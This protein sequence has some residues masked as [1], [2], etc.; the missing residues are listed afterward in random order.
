MLR[1]VEKIIVGN[2][3]FENLG[4]QGLEQLVQESIVSGDYRALQK[5]TN[6]Y[7][8]VYDY[9]HRKPWW[10]LSDFDADVWLVDFTDDKKKTQKKSNTITKMLDWS[11]VYL[12]DAEPLT[13]IKHRKLLNSFKYWITAVDNPLENGGNLI[14]AKTA[15]K[16]FNIV[17]HLINAILLHS[18]SLRLAQLQLHNVNDDF[19]LNILIQIAIHG[20]VSGIYEPDFRIKQLLDKESLSITDEQAVQFEKNYPYLSKSLASDD[21]KLSLSN[22]AKACAWLFEQGFYRDSLG[23]LQLQGN[24]AVLNSLMFDGEVLS[25]DSA[26]PAYLELSLKAPLL[27]TEYPAAA[28]QNTSAETTRNVISAYIAAIR[29]ICTNL[30]RQDAASPQ[31]VGQHVTAVSVSQN[32]LVK[33][34]KPARTRTLPPEFVFNLIRQCY[35]FAKEHLPTGGLINTA[36]PSLLS[37][38]LHCMTEGIS[39]SVQSRPSR[40]AKAFNKALHGHVPTTERGHWFQNEAINCLSP[41]Y[42]SKGITQINTFAISVPNRHKR[43]RANESLFDLFDVLQGSIQIIIGAIMAR[44]QDELV[45]LK[46]HGNLSPNIN[47]FTEKG[48]A[49]NYSLK[50]EVKKTGVGGKKGMNERI[51]RPIPLSIAKFIWQLEQ[52]NIE[53]TQRHLNKG[54]LSLFNCLASKACRLSSLNYHSFNKHLD[55]VCDYFETDLVQY[56]TGEYRRNYVRQHQLRRFF[57]MAFFWSKRFRGMEALRWMLAHSDIEHLYHYISESE[58]GTVLTGVKATTITRSITDPS[59]EL[60]N[61]EEIEELRKVIA[62]RVLGDESKAVELSTLSDA[63]EY[64]EDESYR[65]VP[66]ISQ[67]QKEQAIENEIIDMLEVGSITL[68][69]EFFTI[70][71]VNGDEVRTF[72]LMLRIKDLD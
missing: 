35:E 19:W 48:A 3:N 66:L 53:V 54:T 32:E 39:K 58:Q 60:Y 49:S 12:D 10:L 56:D 43:I 70:T 33:L 67:I 4:V 28:N 59:S 17:V 50:F 47:P 51:E 7:T 25:T 23:S 45:S 22:R 31:Q 30:D 5:I 8:G 6:I 68:E 55:A 71:D 44:R 29:L 69:P 21:I 65:T 2:R 52:F 36:E 64:Y 34:R 63:Y 62:K 24:T 42:I 13:A 27:T 16:K 57:A 1:L 18:K 20:S 38:V 41:D 26:L 46:S 37:E 72:S 15:Y 40:D 9:S 14:K 11:A 61:T